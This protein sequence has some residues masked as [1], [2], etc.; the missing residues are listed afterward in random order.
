MFSDLRFPRTPKPNARRAALPYSGLPAAL[1]V[2]ILLAGCSADVTRFDT[3]LLGANDGASP[4]DPDQAYAESRL[5]EARPSADYVGSAQPAQPRQAAALE[6][7]TIRR[8]ALAPPG[9]ETQRDAY[10][11]PRA[12]YEP[13]R[14]ETSLATTHS[15]PSSPSYE[16][17]APRN[18]QRAPAKSY[19]VADAAPGGGD[20]GASDVVVRPGDTL[21][22]LARRYGVSVGDLKSANGLTTNTIRVGQR[23]MIP[24][25]GS[26]VAARVPSRPALPRDT[27]PS[28]S[29]A[30]DTYTVQPGDSLYRISRM[31]NTRIAD[32]RAWND[33]RDVR[34]LRPGMTLQL[35]PTA[36]SGQ[37]TI[38][39]RRQT[40]EVRQTR[41]ETYRVP[42]PA[43]GQTN[44]DGS[45]TDDRG[46]VTLA[47]GTVAPNVINRRPEGR[48]VASRDPSAGLPR[49][50][51]DRSAAP[52][53]GSGFRWP[54]RGKVISG[55][56]PRKDGSHN[57]GIDIAV[58]MGT[59]IKATDDGVV[60]YAGNELKGYGNLVL[61][62]HDNGW[63]SA[64]AHASD[65]LVRRG[66]A[67]KRGQV[68]AKAG[69]SGAVD[70][71]MLHFELRDG[72]KPVDPLPKLGG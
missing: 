55:F 26:D 46:P 65:L 20:V 60:A 57:D 52:A 47:P 10:L 16:S 39:S 40:P 51:A 18:S 43:S 7:G 30:G 17:Y 32:L 9:G 41:T 53:A 22:G 69:K 29:I 6:T 34:A 28:Q 56:G 63:V 67:V 5:S 13:P 27:R 37:R 36:D 25:A 59:P 68:I 4:V 45:R 70:Q 2:S 72:A 11:E 58:P 3:S 23:L 61:I 62:R 15:L 8:G 21:Y 48:R 1:A 64:Y 38:A 42:R 54:V 71:P 24:S 14:R 49:L 66:D 12:R 35:K 19:R 31:T 50:E 44:A 33:I